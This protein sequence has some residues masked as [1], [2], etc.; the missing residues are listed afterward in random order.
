MVHAI[1][2]SREAVLIDQM[3]QMSDSELRDQTVDEAGYDAPCTEEEDCGE[4]SGD[5]VGDDEIEEVE[6]GYHSKMEKNKGKG[7]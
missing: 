5:K 2:N 6:E 7:K 3:D 1:L 4:M